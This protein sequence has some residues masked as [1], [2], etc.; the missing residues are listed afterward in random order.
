[1]IKEAT[2]MTMR[3]ATAPPTIPAIMPVDR[4]PLSFCAAAVEVGVI[5]AMAEG[6]YLSTAC[7][8]SPEP[9]VGRVDGM[10]GVMTV[11]TAV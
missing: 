1:M 7:S 6:K 10:T 2:R 5:L 11:T 9:A 4:P 8:P 3:N